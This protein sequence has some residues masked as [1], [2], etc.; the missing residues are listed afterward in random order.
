[1]VHISPC[2]NYVDHGFYSLSP[3]LYSDYYMANGYDDVRT[4]LARHTRKVEGR[5]WKI[6]RYTPGGLE[7]VA[8]GGL[9]D[10]LYMT[11]AVATKVERSTCTVVPQQFFYSR[12]WDGT[13]PRYS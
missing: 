7:F 6:G 8:F 11:V 5:P 3:T 12:I 9:D 2:N 10:A 4:F 13:R 1:M